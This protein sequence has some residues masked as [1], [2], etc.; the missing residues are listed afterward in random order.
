METLEVACVRVGATVEEV[1]SF[2]ASEDAVDAAIAAA[3]LL[4]SRIGH[5]VM[6]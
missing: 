3:A 6:S 5:L 1:D 4:L 2:S